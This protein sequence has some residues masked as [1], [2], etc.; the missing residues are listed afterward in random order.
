MVCI[1]IM[2]M[3]CRGTG[4]GSGKMGL[5]RVTSGTRGVPRL[6][7]LSTMAGLSRSSWKLLTASSA[8]VSHVWAT[9]DMTRAHILRNCSSSVSGNGPAL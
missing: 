3:P 6:K 1:T 8:V 4:I 5:T 9:L 2:G 7:T